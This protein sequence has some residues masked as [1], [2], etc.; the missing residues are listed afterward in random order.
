[1]K[2]TFIQKGLVLCLIAVIALSG[3]TACQTTG[4]STAGSA[5]M[6]SRIVSDGKFIATVNLANAPW[7]SQDANG[8]YVGLSI[9]L[10][11]GFAAGIGV[12]VEIMPLE[13]ASL[14]PAIESGKADIIITNLSRT[15]P[16][17]TKVLYT[18]PVGGSPGVA[19]I[20]KGGKYSEETTIADLN[21]P[22][23]LLTTEVG[24]I[25]ETIA[26]EKFPNATMSAVNQNSDAMA[27][28]KAGRAEV[29]LT[30]KDVADAMVA[31]DP[32]VTYL[33]ELVFADSFA[34]AVKLSSDSYTFV[35]TFNNYLKLIKI[36]G[37]YGKL[38]EQYFNAPWVPS[39]IEVGY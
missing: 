3:L 9:D 33:N 22:G 24:T 34:F 15:I 21:Q 25:H 16:R 10:I 13:F 23:V 36:D 38:Y 17:S 6:L 20:M 4:G 8:E 28:L 37:T 19:V 7:A 27:A 35:E 39:S 2:K 30:G 11:K 18:E 26:A 32:N 1:M 14:I 5:D 31:V 12:E 29:F